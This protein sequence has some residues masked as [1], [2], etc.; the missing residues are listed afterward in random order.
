VQVIKVLV[1]GFL[2]KKS[3]VFISNKELTG[4]IESHRLGD[5]T[6]QLK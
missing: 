4:Q 6:G 2:P 5:A 1:K 3:F